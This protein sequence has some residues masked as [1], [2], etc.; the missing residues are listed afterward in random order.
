MN[1][2]KRIVC[3]SL[4]VL[5]LGTI[6]ASAASNMGTVAYNKAGIICNRQTAVKTG[7]SITAADGE[8]IPSVITYTDAQGKD[9]NYLSVRQISEL[10][11]IPISWDSRSSSVVLGNKKLEQSY[12]VTVEE[13][14]PESVHVPN[15]GEYES[16]L[17]Y[18]IYDAPVYSVQAGSFTETDPSK[19]PA[20][21]KREDPITRRKSFTA[22][23][24]LNEEEGCTPGATTR[25][26]FTNHSEETQSVY[27][28]RRP[29]G[30]LTDVELFS[31]VKIE[32]EQTVTR[33]FYL[34]EDAPAFAR[35]LTWC[36]AGGTVT[37]VELT[38]D[39][40]WG[41]YE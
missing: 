5:M 23:C 13:G 6:G 41:K 27:I 28:I 3:F 20:D 33:A 35:T 34:E 21:A 38:V 30:S 16:E 31:K 14:N 7:A 25:L 2:R 8:T 15:Q 19:I 12:V 1:N 22:N 29:N 24:Q 26:S 17:V 37:D 40:F 10:F 4:A 11:D 9:T 32:P 36:M 18:K 39:S